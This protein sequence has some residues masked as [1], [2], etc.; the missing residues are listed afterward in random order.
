MNNKDLENIVVISYYDS[1]YN[2]SIMK[3]GI[4]SQKYCD[5][6]NTENESK[7]NAFDLIYR[8]SKL[9]EVFPNKTIIVCEDGDIEVIE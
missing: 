9:K 1:G 5:G 6:F 2:R 8:K 3:N 4:V 7:G